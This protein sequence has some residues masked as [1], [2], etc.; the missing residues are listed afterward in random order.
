MQ[1][2]IVPL[3]TLD[4]IIAYNIVAGPLDSEHFLKFIKD[5]LISR[6]MPFMNPYPSPCSVL[7]MDNC[8]IYHGEQIHQL[9]K[10]ENCKCCA[11]IYGISTLI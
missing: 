11:D 4:G 10:D 2:S 5:H 6:G 7:I 8:H 1:Y 9:V 3:I